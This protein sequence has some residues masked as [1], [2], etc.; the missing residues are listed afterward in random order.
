MSAAEKR[1]VSLQE[2]A[3]LLGVHRNTLSAW[4]AR[5]APTLS[6]ARR[7]DGVA[8]LVDLGAVMTWRA[9]QARAEEREK[10]KR[11]AEA[12]RAQLAELSGEGP[13]VA[14]EE[15]RRRKALA[16]AR[17]AEVELAR[18]ESRFVDADALMAFLTPTLLSVRDRL[19]RVPNT[20]GAVIPG[21]TAEQVAELEQLVRDALTEIAEEGEAVK[22]AADQARAEDRQTRRPA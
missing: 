13:G 4:I 16:Q 1:A 11:E 14:I 9:E 3:R 12:L 2:A 18:Q 22:R 8:W 6:A 19:L 15:S 10:A 17:M 20:A 7:A 5:G 21:M